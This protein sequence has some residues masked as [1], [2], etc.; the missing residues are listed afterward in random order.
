MKRL[1]IIL[2]LLFIAVISYSAVDVTVRKGVNMATYTGTAS[3]TINGTTTAD[4]IFYIEYASEGLY[5]I[6]FFIDGDTLNTCS[7]NVTIQAQGS[8]DDN[9]YTNIG[10]SVTWTTTADYAGNTN[11]NTTTITES[12]SIA[13]HDIH[14]GGTYSSAAYNVTGGALGTDT[15][16]VQADTLVYPAITYTRDDTATVEAQT[17]TNTNTITLPGYDFPYVKI[18]LTGLSG[19]RVELQKV[20][21]KVT[22]ISMKF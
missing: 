2:S 13:T 11:R 10:S 19:A 9:T 1:I 15:I 20:V 4:A 3:D 16:G 21:L 8:Y 7:G 18:K 14:F 17:W 12:G 5:V 22:P 6:S